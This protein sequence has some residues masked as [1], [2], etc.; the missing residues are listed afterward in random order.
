MKLAIAFLEKQNKLHEDV[1]N[2]RIYQKKKAKEIMDSNISNDLKY[3]RIIRFVG[4][5]V[6]YNK[7]EHM[8]IIKALNVLRN[9]K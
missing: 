9:H 2:H 5:P 8:S 6:F 4:D 1:Y 3:G 7:E